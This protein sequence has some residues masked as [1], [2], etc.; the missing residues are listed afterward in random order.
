MSTIWFIY[1]MNYAQNSVLNGLR[2]AWSV[3]GKNSTNFGKPIFFSTDFDNW[4]TKVNNGI[5]TEVMQ[6]GR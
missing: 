4:V 2:G 1:G 6:E 3:C 5:G